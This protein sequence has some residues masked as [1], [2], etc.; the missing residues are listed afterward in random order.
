MTI[1][2]L[3]APLQI[4][5]PASETLQQ[6]TSLTLGAPSLFVRANVAAGIN[7]Q[8]QVS[9]K[10]Q[11]DTLDLASDNGSFLDATINIDDGVNLA[12]RLTGVLSKY[13]VNGGPASSFT[14]NDRSSF[15]GSDVVFNVDV[16]GQGAIQSGNAYSHQ[17]T[18]E[19]ARGVAVG[20]T[21]LA[22]GA[23]HRMG[24]TDL[25][26][27]QPSQYHAVTEV[28]GPAEV[29]LAGVAADSYT[30]Q[31]NTLTLY[32]GDTVAY[33]MTLVQVP[34]DV[35]QPAPPPF[36]V[37]RTSSGVA[38]DSYVPAVLVAKD[39]AALSVRGAPQPA[40]SPPAPPPTSPAPPSDSGTPSTS[41]SN[42][43]AAP[44]PS[45]SSAPP[46]AP[47]PA[48]NSPPAASNTN[49]VVVDG[50]A[51]SG[52]NAS[53][54]GVSNSVAPASGGDTPTP[55]S[56]AEV[57]A[58]QLA[59]QLNPPAGGAATFFYAGAHVG[60]DFDLLGSGVSSGQDQGTALNQTMTDLK[61][62]LSA[63]ANSAADLAKGVGVPGGPQMS[64]PPQ[65]V[66]DVV[67]ASLKAMV[68][69]DAGLDHA[70]AGAL[71]QFFGGEV[72]AMLGGGHA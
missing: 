70:Y 39:H 46:P 11:N 47:P 61:Q 14:N 3:D 66:V 18:L 45:D 53:S 58:V 62:F 26:I 32:S 7:D 28:Q 54:G 17:G 43:V 59:A 12:G 52:G 55:L 67:N 44:P 1:D 29:D 60:R 57:G 22:L 5:D 31:N 15:A 56:P 10:Q 25:Q 72:S 19:F 63:Y 64:V 2:Q 35:P 20:E 51:G 48:P 13:V 37:S 23:P 21:V 34:A 65:F 71:T 36:V 4:G 9:A 16:G 8:L 42:P 38:I 40:P 41:P 69:G 30:Y 33:T 50:G 6:T 27:D 49:T 68:I 24:F